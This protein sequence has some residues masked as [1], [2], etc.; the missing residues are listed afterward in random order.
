MMSLLHRNHIVIKKMSG[1]RTM[2]RRQGQASIQADI[3][4]DGSYN[5]QI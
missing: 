1:R 3:L 4:T 2:K 5:R